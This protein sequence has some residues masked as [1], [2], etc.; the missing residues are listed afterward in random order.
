MRRYGTMEMH[1]HG[2]QVARDQDPTVISRN[3]Q[4][5]SI[6]SS[7][8]YYTRGWSKVYRGLSSEEPFANVGIDVG[9]GLKAD[10]QAGLGASFWARSKRSIMS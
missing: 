5:F 9:V 10:F 4:N 6:E 2:S 7:V 3:A 1:G 8:R